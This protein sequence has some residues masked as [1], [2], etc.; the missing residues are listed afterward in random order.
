MPVAGDVAVSRGKASPFLHRTHQA[1]SKEAGI[2]ESLCHDEVT[3]QMSVKLSQAAHGRSGASKPGQWMLDLGGG[4]L[5]RC[6]GGSQGGGR[7]VPQP[8]QGAPYR[9]QVANFQT[10]L[11]WLS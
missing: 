6:C 1:P 10:T 4:L 11:L 2:N 7:R 9:L 3:I 8:G 5:R